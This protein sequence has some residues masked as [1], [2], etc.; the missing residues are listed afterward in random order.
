MIAHI[1]ILFALILANGVF[2]MAEIAVV[3]ARP[4]RLRQMAEKGSRGAQ[5]AMDLAESPG[6]FLATIQI[7]ITMVGVGAGA[8]GEATL[9]RELEPAL[10]V[11]VALGRLP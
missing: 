3:S 2:A 8:F 9:A 4:T 10:V 5:I 11:A 7:G 1:L 6:R